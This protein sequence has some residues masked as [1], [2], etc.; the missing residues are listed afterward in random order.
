MLDSDVTNLYPSAMWDE[1]S[2]YSK[3]ETGY[4]QTKYMNN[5]LVEKFKT[6]TFTQGSAIL[7]IR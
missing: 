2:N 7:K 3:I 1:K 4:V 6:Q 5:G